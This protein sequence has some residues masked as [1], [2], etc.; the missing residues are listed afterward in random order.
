MAVAPRTL[1]LTIFSVGIFFSASAEQVVP[2]YKTGEVAKQEI[3]TPFKMVVLNAEATR[4]LREKEALRVPTIFQFNPASVGQSESN[5]FATLNYKREEFQNKLE[6]VFARRTLGPKYIS[7]PRYQRVVGNFLRQNKAF[8]VTTNLLELWAK[9]ESDQSIRKSLAA[10]LRAVAEHYIRADSLPLN[11]KLGAQVRIVSTTNIAG[12]LSEDSVTQGR[13]M[14]RSNI[15]TLTKA[16]AEVLKRF[17]S[18]NQRIAKAVAA[19]LHENCVLD[20]EQSKAA[21]A[22]K[23][24][25]LW[26]TDGY[27]AGDAIVKSGQTIDAKAVAALDQ[28]REK[29][30]VNQLQQ[31]ASIPVPK[32]QPQQNHW[33]LI[34]IGALSAM[35]ALA[36]IRFTTRKPSVNTL[37]AKLRRTAASEMLIACPSCEE[38]ISVPVSG[39][40]ELVLPDDVSEAEWKQRALSAEARV[41]AARNAVQQGLVR[42]LAKLFREKFVAKIVRHRDELI[43]THEQA[44]TSVAALEARLREVNAPLQ[45]RL[46]AYQRRIAELEKELTSRGEENRELIKAKIHL[47]KT[48]SELAKA[49]E[50]MEFNQSSDDSIVSNPTRWQ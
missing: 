47:A 16:R 26:I 14:Q 28:L 6:S 40:Q 41:A 43:D 29:L 21:R 38:N 25:P 4:A 35:L 37:P 31:E 10:P 24:D 8:P 17:A 13:L 18:E 22:K 48:Q 50:Q 1:L 36:L 49:K 45:E 7:M 44:A 2:N 33:M 46:L 30:K 39:I 11:F 12:K 15:F 23:I 5:L 34:L 42:H 19:M 27:E 32:P 20:F 3:K 9:G